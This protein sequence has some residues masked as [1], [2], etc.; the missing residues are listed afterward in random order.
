MP[1]ELYNLFTRDW[2]K[3]VVCKVTLKIKY[4]RLGQFI[5]L[6]Q[7]L[8]ENLHESEENLFKERNRNQ[9]TYHHMDKLR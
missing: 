4:I 8:K 9:E 3:I 2:P 1:G 6:H 5:L 7:E